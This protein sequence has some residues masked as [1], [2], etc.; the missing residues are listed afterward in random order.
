MRCPPPPT[1]PPHR[2]A[3]A[4]ARVRAHAHVRR[5]QARA[6]RWD[7][8]V[9]S[10]LTPLP[11]QSPHLAFKAATYIPSVSFLDPAVCA[12]ARARVC[13]TQGLCAH[14]CPR[15]R[16]PARPRLR[17]NT[18]TRHTKARCC[19]HSAP[20][21]QRA[22]RLR[23]HLRAG[24]D[25]ATAACC[26]KSAR[27]L[28]P[29]TPAHRP[30]HTPT[31][32]SEHRTHAPLLLHFFASIHRRVHNT[33]AGRGPGLPDSRA[34]VHPPRPPPAPARP[35]GAVGRHAGQAHPE[36]APC[37]RYDASV[38]PSRAA[39]LRAGSGVRRPGACCWR[40]QRIDPRS[41]P[42]VS[43]ESEPGSWPALVRFRLSR[44]GHSEASTALEK[45]QAVC[46]AQP[47]GGRALALWRHDGSLGSSTTR[48][49]IVECPR[50]V[51]HA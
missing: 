4:R 8:D 37:A 7:T 3:R 45:F 46:M 10:A 2:R 34:G 47:R 19:M 28:P 39:G 51:G 41:S 26:Y 22:H 6:Q 27:P 11:P 21:G 32:S 12:R 50:T 13:L 17:A 35:P 42:R 30:P 38:I 16:A 43:R 36:H 1:P 44:R 20:P 18:R 40:A 24:V 33:P 23:W 14:P 25:R 15:A 49:T 31:P 29:L 5:I 9:D 48:S